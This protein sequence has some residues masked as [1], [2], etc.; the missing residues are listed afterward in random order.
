MRLFVWFLLLLA[1]FSCGQPNPLVPNVQTQQTIS[2]SDMKIPGTD[3]GFIYRQSVHVNGGGNAMYS[4]KI[5]TLSAQLP[6]GYVTDEDGWLYFYK[7]GYETVAQ[8]TEPGEHRT[9]WTA[10]PQLNLEFASDGAKLNN[11]VT[12]VEV[13]V[14]DDDGTIT[15][16]ESPFKSDRLIGS[17]IEVPFAHGATT[18]TGIEFNLRENIGD[19]YVEG[20]YAHHFMYRLN[21][22]NSNM[23]VISTGTWYNSINT[24]DI[25][26]VLLN[27][28]SQPTLSVTAQNC[29]TQFESYVVSRQGIEEASRQNVYFRA[30]GGNKPKAIIY[31]EAFVG[32]GQYH[33]SIA[34]GGYASGFYE[35][36]MSTGTGY[37]R[38]LWE[39]GFSKN[40]VNSPDFKLH[41]R[42]GHKGLYES[43]NPFSLPTSV[44]L[45]EQGQAYYSK[46]VAY[47]L[48]LDGAPFPV[49][50]GFFEP[51]VVTHTDGTSWLRVYNMFDRCR[52]AVLGNLANGD[53]TFQVIAEDLQGVYSDP[54]S[55]TFRLEAYKPFAQRSGILIVDDSPN[56][57]S[58]SPE[59]IVDSFYSAVVPSILGN[60]STLDLEAAGSASIAA[61]YPFLQDYKAVIWHS[62]NPAQTPHLR[63]NID[64]LDCYLANGGNL[65]LSSTS[66]LCA[67]LDEI[68]LESYGFF[69]NRL[70]LIHTLS[71][72]NLGNT[73]TLNPFFVQALGVNGIS[74]I[75]LE[76]DAPFNSIV[77]S[78]KGLSAVTY[79]NADAELNNVYRFG[80]KPANSPN[81][82]PTMEQFDLYSSKYVGYRFSSPQGSNVIVLGFPLSYMKQSE[83]TIAVQ[84]LLNAITG[85]SNKGRGLK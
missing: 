81:Y 73:L 9:I 15:T 62:D 44:C 57:T 16:C 55:F 3:G 2:F 32:L 38:V 25:R 49:Q 82:P 52:H 64:A 29:Y 74:N 47:H 21:V 5:S 84:E 68:S 17:R 24:P 27:G 42:W 50:T 72:G 69:H 26:K 41:I 10:N 59:Q 20:L 11:L 43:D 4:Y 39:G 61:G 56:H 48:R 67:A 23:D 28:N 70:G 85:T 40:A 77:N 53:H 78:R 33:Y 7:P 45:N 66:K 76:L 63:N 22:L 18:G 19:I 14:K 65:L 51:S 46:I 12:K 35:Q 60:V 31:P 1:L 75:S 6:A 37:N 83:V 54:E 36:I 13:R 30:I 58:Y 79:F 80:C 34:Q 8:I 71:Y